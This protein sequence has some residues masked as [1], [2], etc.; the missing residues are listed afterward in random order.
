MQE[1]KLSEIPLD[2]HPSIVEE[3]LP[4]GNEFLHVLAGLGEKEARI[5]VK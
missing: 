1:F 4:G 5:G 2:T 3:R